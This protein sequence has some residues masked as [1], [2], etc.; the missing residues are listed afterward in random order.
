MQCSVLDTI[1]T[2]LSNPTIFD[3]DPHFK[4]DAVLVAQAHPLFA[5]LWIF[6]SGGLDDLYAWQ[7]V[8]AGAVGELGTYF[9]FSPTINARF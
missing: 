1:A 3:F 8:H 6:L 9:F 4:L 7:H 2:A 5:L